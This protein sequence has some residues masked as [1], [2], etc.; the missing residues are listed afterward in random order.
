VSTSG[1]VEVILTGSIAALGH[2]QGAKRCTRLEAI[3]TDLSG[4]RE[5]IH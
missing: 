4:R 3:A 1:R 5:T 2:P